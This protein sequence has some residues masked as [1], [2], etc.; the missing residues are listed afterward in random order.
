[1]FERTVEA[2]ESRRAVFNASPGVLGAG[3][4]SLNPCATGTNHK[5]QFVEFAAKH[6]KRVYLF[7]GAVTLRKL[8]VRINDNLLSTPRPI[9]I[10]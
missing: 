2:N 6:Q 4:L 5:S 3:V 1:M 10:Y 8:V 9:G 7:R